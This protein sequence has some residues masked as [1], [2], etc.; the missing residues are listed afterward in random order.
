MACRAQRG[1]LPNHPTVARLP[2]RLCTQTQ[3]HHSTTHSTPG[4]GGHPGR[5]RGALQQS[6]RGVPPCGGSHKPL[7][8][9]GTDFERGNRAHYTNWQG[10]VYGV[11]GSGIR[12]GQGAGGDYSPAQWGGEGRAP[13]QSARLGLVPCR[14]CAF[15][16]AIDAGILGVGEGRKGRMTGM[17][18]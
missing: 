15:T 16:T 8:A 4:D 11:G 2:T 13:T 17:I 18:C 1:A 12:G 7:G 14:Q 9:T 5:T 3:Q 6:R 10:H